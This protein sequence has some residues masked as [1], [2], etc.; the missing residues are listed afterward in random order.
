M[1]APLLVLWDID[2]TLL[3]NSVA[4]P[5]IYAEAFELATGRPLEHRVPMVGR[6]ELE[7]FAS[8][9]ASHG[10]EPVAH[11]FP[12][13]ADL[14]TAGYVA[15]AG[16][17]REHGRA[18]PGAEAAL[19]ALSALPGVRQSVLTGNIRPVAELK[20]AAFGL[21][22]H[23]DFEAGA[24]GDDHAERWRLVP[25]ARRRAEAR[26][27]AAFDH[28]STVLV[29]DSPNDVAAGR[30]GGA[31][32]VAVASGRNTADELSAAGA[33]VVLPDLCDTEAFVRA[34]RGQGGTCTA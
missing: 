28:A 16:R 25:V 12:A 2:W 22:R 23:V 17:V 4:G 5:G 32:V 24:Y 7:I 14:L 11:P 26:W 34:V 1:P 31:R 6:T 15:G 29:G 20:L 19:V 9:L 13:F 21:A 10:L 30:D 3:E 27:G 33:D 8:A 18:L